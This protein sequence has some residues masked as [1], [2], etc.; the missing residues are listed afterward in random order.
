M[1]N[2]IDRYIE[3]TNESSKSFM[4]RV[5]K[6]N[7]A[8]NLIRKKKKTIIGDA[9]KLWKKDIIRKKKKLTKQ[10]AKKEELERKQHKLALK[11]K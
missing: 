9:L 1:H 4:S 8:R 2:L 6:Q 5:V 10:L 3:L 11:G 7:V